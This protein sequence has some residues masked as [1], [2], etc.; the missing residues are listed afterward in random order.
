MQW[1]LDNG[2]NADNVNADGKTA[3]DMATKAVKVL[4][5]RHSKKA[6]LD[7]GDACCILQ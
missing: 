7:E 6:T 5:E 4:L 3:I 1:L 2:A